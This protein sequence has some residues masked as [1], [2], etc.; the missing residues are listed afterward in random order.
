M[1][2]VVFPPNKDISTT[3]YQLYEFDSKCE[4]DLVVS[5]KSSIVCNSNQNAGKKA[6]G[7]AKSY[8]RLELKRGQ[9]LLYS[10]YIDLA[11]NVNDEDIENGFNVMKDTLPLL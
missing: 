3:L 6:L 1:N 8:L 9:R 11:E 7:M 4:L 2:L 5:Y 10:Y